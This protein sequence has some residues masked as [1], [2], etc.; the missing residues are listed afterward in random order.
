M[1]INI[2]HDPSAVRI[3]LKIKKNY[4]YLIH[5]SL[6]ILMLHTQLITVGFSDG[7]VLIGP[8]VPDM[9]VKIMDIVGFLLPDPEDLIHGTL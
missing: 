4:V 1:Y 9:A 3:V 5:H 8:A 2:G 6:F 7:T